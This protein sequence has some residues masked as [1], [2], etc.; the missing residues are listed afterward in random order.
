MT[1]DQ[2]NQAIEEAEHEHMAAGFVVDIAQENLDAARDKARE[3]RNKLFAL[4][5]QRHEMQKETV[6]Q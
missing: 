4:Y 1:P 3:S 5:K 6:S 2:L